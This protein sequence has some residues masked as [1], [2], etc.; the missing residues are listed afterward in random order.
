V[1]KWWSEFN[2]DGPEIAYYQRFIE[3]GGEPAL[4]V[5]CGTCR[6]LLPYLRAG[7]DVDGC[8]VSA[9]MVALCREQAAR[10]GLEHVGFAEV[11]VRGDYTDDEATTDTLVFVARRR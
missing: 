11:E 5:A 10:E 4:D 2:T 3:G 8:D 1:A 7:L 9:D 6:L